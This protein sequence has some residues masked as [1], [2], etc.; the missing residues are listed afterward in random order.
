MVVILYF[1]CYLL[2]VG[3][4]L[5]FCSKCGAEVAEDEKFCA[6]CGTPMGVEKVRVSPSNMITVTTPTVPGYRVKHVITIVTGLTARTRG[7]GGK[8]VAGIQSMFGGEVSAFTSEI[9]KARDE[10]MDRMKEKA[11]RVG[12]NAIIGLDIETSD[13]LQGTIL[14]SATGTAV[15]IEPE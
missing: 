4:K 5:P 13:V 9:E 12:A 7:V 2:V 8:F 10:A 15:V 14:I 6:T 1:T 3:D 11:R